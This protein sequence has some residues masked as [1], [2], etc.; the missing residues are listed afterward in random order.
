M[1][2]RGFHRQI[3]HQDSHRNEWTSSW[4]ISTLFHW[5][6]VIRSLKWKCWKEKSRISGFKKTGYN[7]F[8][9]KR[10]S[11]F[12]VSWCLQAYLITWM[13]LGYIV[14]LYYFR[15]CNA[16]SW[17]LMT[18]QCWM[19]HFWILSILSTKWARYNKAVSLKALDIVLSGWHINECL[20]PWKK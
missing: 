7:S 2:Q 14:L 11:L 1:L 13:L 5:K 15:S 20:L 18:N 6:Q 9:L 10:P 3:D 4:Q 12:S 16:Y 19:E 8:K 17:I